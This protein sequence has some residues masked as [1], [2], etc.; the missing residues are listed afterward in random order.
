[1][2]VEGG[3][4][5][6]REGGVSRSDGRPACWHRPARLLVVVRHKYWRRSRQDWNG[7]D[8]DS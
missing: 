1:M 8:S 2:W 3:S 5:V 6:L 4:E 7:E